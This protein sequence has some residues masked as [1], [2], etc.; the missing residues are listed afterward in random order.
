MEV[1]L[2]EKI[3]KLG[4]IGAVVTVKDGYGRNYLLPRKKALR[5]TRE[6]KAFFESKRGEIEAAH[7]TNRSE[8]VILAAKLENYSVNLARQAGEDGKLFGSVNSRDI[9][10]AIRE[11]GIEVS[12]NSIL[13][14]SAIK[15][16]GSFPVTL[17]LHSDV[18][19]KIT[20]NIIRPEKN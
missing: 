4:P 15:Y 9:S 17:H 2:L 19:V 7:D 5:A 3:A 10:M 6:N 16:L 12:K 1:I 18:D 8:A 11:T 13:L 14:D 20:V